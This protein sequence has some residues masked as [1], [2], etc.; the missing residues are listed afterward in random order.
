MISEIAGLNAVAALRDPRVTSV[1]VGA[2]SVAQLDDSLDAS[3]TGAVFATQGA[4]AGFLEPT[5]TASA[6]SRSHFRPGMFQSVLLATGEIGQ[7]AE[8]AAD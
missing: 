8:I 5:G 6:V 1:L 7:G 4:V 3:L 2:S